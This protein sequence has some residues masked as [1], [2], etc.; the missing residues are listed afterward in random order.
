MRW[1]ETESEMEREMCLLYVV[2][3]EAVCYIFFSREDI[4][5]VLLTLQELDVV[6][7]HGTEPWN[8]GLAAYA[9]KILSDITATFT[10]DHAQ[11]TGGV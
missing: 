7:S 2:Q 3:S 11:C 5:T 9:V 8:L 4:D 1:R 6:W 10:L